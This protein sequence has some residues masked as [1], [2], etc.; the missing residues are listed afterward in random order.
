LL[1]EQDNCR[2]ACATSIGTSATAAYRWVW[3]SQRISRFGSGRSDVI[4]YGPRLQ[5]STPALD[6]R[7]V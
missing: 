6:F 3:R 5:L 7:V 1:I 4:W 2:I